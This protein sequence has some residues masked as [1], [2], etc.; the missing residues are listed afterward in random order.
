MANV[1]AVSQPHCCKSTLG[2]CLEK[3]SCGTPLILADWLTQ[4]VTD[5]PMWANQTAIIE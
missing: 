4:M 1:D 5:D 3:K 2:L